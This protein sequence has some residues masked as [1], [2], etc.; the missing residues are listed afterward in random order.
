MEGFFIC[1]FIIAMWGIAILFML[2][3]DVVEKKIATKRMPEKTSETDKERLERNIRIARY[4]CSYSDECKFKSDAERKQFIVELQKRHIKHDLSPMYRYSVE[5]YEMTMPLTV[6]EAMKQIE[7]ER[8]IC[9]KSCGSSLP[10]IDVQQWNKLELLKLRNPK[11][12]DKALYNAMRSSWWRMPNDDTYMFCILDLIV[13]IMTVDTARLVLYID[14]LS[15]YGLERLMKLI[16]NKL[17]R[18]K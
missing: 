9:R 3:I 17:D 14:R 10:W 13:N 4:N 8:D 2:N 5:Q 6:V 12:Y 7:N 15:P 18:L 11:V 16:G 1:A